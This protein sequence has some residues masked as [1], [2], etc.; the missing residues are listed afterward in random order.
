MAIDSVKGNFGYPRPR[1]TSKAPAAPAPR[2]K[3]KTPAREDDKGR[4][5]E[6]DGHK[7]EG[8]SIDERV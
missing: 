4:P 2:S 8:S 7:P 3:T 6:R 1:K 5:Q